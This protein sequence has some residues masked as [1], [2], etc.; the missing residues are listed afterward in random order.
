VTLKA[1]LKPAALERLSSGDYRFCPAAECAVVYF[2]SGATF[3]RED[4]LATVFQKEAEGRRTVCY[5]LDV[6]EEQLHREVAATGRSRSADRIRA[7]I[8]NDRCACELRNPQGTCCLGNVAAV[9]RSVQKR[10]ST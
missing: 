8:T 1:L 6:T 5:C 9:M 4:V 2:G 7:L 3:L 10:C